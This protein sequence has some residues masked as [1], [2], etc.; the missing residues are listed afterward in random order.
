MS[1]PRPGRA[2]DYTH[3]ALAMGFVNLFWILGLV[4]VV[5]GLP[6]VLIVALLLNHLID[7]LAASRSA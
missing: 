3:A 7:R 1:S 6:A 5:L 2:P 4:W